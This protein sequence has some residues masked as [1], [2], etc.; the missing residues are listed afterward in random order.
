MRKIIND[1]IEDGNNVMGLVLVG[2]K[3]V[4]FVFCLLVGGINFNICIF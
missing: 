2:F 4:F 3:L 1:R